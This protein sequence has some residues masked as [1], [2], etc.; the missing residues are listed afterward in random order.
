VTALAID[1]ISAVD[2]ETRYEPIRA[3]ERATFARDGF[4]LI[5]DAL[6]PSLWSR[7]VKA[8]NRI[9]DQEQ[10]AGRLRADGSLHLLGM[11]RR[12]PVFLDLLDYPRTFRYVWGLL[13][14]NVYTHHHHLD[15]HP[16][17]APDEPVPWNWHQDGYRQNSDID[18]A[19]RPMLSVKI[20]FVLSDMSLPG[21]GATKIIHGSHLRNTLVGRPER[22][23]ERYDEPD[24]AEE[25][26]A[27]AGDAFIFDRRLWHSRSVN[28][29]ALTRKIV[30]I[31]YTHRWI[32]PLDETDYRRDP[33]WLA[34]MSPLRR[35]LLGDGT[36][37]ANFWGVRPDGWVDRD[38][39][40]RTELAERGLLDRSAPYLR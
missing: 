23:D 15:V 18:A 40:L 37:N 1:N 32:R 16:G 4:L 8:T 24:G 29:S 21:R 38:I 9:Y 26:I 10:R 2:E 35:Q 28:I 33:Q 13:G 27:R 34:G 17:F 3:D 22:P 7:A 11:L 20:A 6:T 39:P 5:P 31:G 25:I 14:W 12:D 30:F 19:T 36:D